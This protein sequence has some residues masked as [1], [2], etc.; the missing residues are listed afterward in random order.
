M[1]SEQQA[2]SVRVAVLGAG[3]IG[4]AVALGWLR[5]GYA[6]PRELLLVRR[7]LGELDARLGECAQS[8]DLA[9]AARRA[10]WLL[11][12]LPVA[13][14]EP[15]LR[16][17]R[18][19]LGADHV[20]LCC[21]ARI[22][23]AQLRAWAG[24]APRLAR[25]MPNVAAAVC[26]SMTCIS[27]ADAA[28]L[29]VARE[30]FAPLG[31][32]ECVAEA[33]LNSATVLCACGLAFML[34]AVRGAAQGGVEIGFHADQASRLAAQTARGAASLLLDPRYGVA[35][36]EQGIDQVTTPQG[37]T[38]VGLNQL[39]H[40]GFSSALIKAVL[41]SKRRIDGMLDKGT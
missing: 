25:V 3:N 23:E 26:E 36:A 10:R 31:R 2:D 20:V 33:L 34:R 6:A 41:A 1:A 21:A 17:L 24:P 8:T 27:G 30:L 4:S 38:I 5:S 14:V 37:C 16:A 29:A 22:D 39:E 28:A 12:A 35:H 7:N 11:V 13:Q 15:A 9:E 32:V 19:L 40:G 18:P